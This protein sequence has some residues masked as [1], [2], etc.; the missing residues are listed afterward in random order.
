MSDS[1]VRTHSD[2]RQKTDVGTLSFPPDEDVTIS[3][4][5]DD[6]GL[7]ESA[8]IRNAA[9]HKRINSRPDAALLK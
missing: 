2:A 1:A 9:L 6:F 7:T 3:N 5:A 8:F 4:T